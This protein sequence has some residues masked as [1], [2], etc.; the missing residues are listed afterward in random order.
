MVMAR[1]PLTF[2]QNV[3]VTN[4]TY[5]HK[6]GIIE[7]LSSKAHIIDIWL[8]LRL[9]HAETMCDA[10]TLPAKGDENVIRYTKDVIPTL[11]SFCWN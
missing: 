7:I 11:R 4:V 5:N 9:T 10:Y 6:R 3:G 1:V 2:S 8:L